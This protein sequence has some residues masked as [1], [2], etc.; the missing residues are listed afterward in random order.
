MEGP[1]FRAIAN[2]EPDEDKEHPANKAGR[3]AAKLFLPSLQVRAAG[4]GG[5]GAASHLRRQSCVGGCGDVLQGRLPAARGG[6]LQIYL[7]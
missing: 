5:G 4:S 1:T 6:R 2:P 3:E 7:G